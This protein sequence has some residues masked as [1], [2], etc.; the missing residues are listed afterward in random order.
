MVVLVKGHELAVGVLPFRV[1]EVR[2][3]A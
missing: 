1:F 2:H 3:V